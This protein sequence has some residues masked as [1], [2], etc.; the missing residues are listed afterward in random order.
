MGRGRNA[1]CVEGIRT[2][3]LRPAS[4]YTLAEAVR[5]LGLSRSVLI[6]EAR[7]DRAEEY[8]VGCR[9]RFTWRQLALIAFRRWSL[10]DIVDSLG[11]D[12]TQ[13]FPPLQSLR[14]IAIRL[15]EYIIRAL[16]MTASDFGQS[17][18]DALRGELI[19]FAGT[20]TERM[21][22]ILPGY[23]AAYLYPGRQVSP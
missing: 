21:G 22:T 16:E 18:D 19:D 17:I 5:L 14:T 20:M 6:R 11:S 3:F 9:W 4:F 7:S 23:R 10:N 1:I 13:V 8:R 15:P 12:A 2:L